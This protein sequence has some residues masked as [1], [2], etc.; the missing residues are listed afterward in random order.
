MSDLPAT[1]SGGTSASA[2]M[3]RSRTS[4][5][6]GSPIAC[7]DSAASAR[8]R[9]PVRLAIPRPSGTRF[10]TQPST[11]LIASYR[12]GDRHRPCKIAD[13]EIVDQCVFALVNE[14]QASSRRASRC[15]TSDLDVVYTHGVR[16]S[17]L[18]RR[19]HVLRRAPLVSI[20]SMQRCTSSRRTP[21]PTRDSGNP[22]TA[23][24]ATRR[25]RQDVQRLIFR[26]G[27]H[28]RCRH[29]IHR[30]H[31]TCQILARRLSMDAGDDGGPRRSS[32][33]R[34]GAPRSCR[35]R[36]RSDGLRVPEGATGSNIARQIALTAPDA[37]SASRHDGESGFCS[38]GSTIAIAAQ[39]LIRG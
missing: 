39:R 34:A 6:R 7:A 29:R 35:S 24:A 9:G 33:A 11:E 15:R 17:A 8:R 14:A 25:C 37:R 28:G 32:R 3:S 4:S 31:G 13:D 2:A 16:L 23:A 38:S 1:T 5:I 12:E 22:P 30:P 20:E 21:T 26:R 36:R 19:A 10:R 27:C 18:S